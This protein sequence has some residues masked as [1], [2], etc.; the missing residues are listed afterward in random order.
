VLAVAGQ[1]GADGT[2]ETGATLVAAMRYGAGRTLVFAPADSWR[3]RTSASGDEDSMG[4]AFN[5]LWQGIA[6]WTAAGAQPPVEI[7]L[8]DESPA[9]GSMVTAELRVRDASFAPAK[10]EKLGA[11]LQPLTE[12]AGDSSA[13][14]T[15][16][17][18]EIIFAPDSL[19]KSVWR[20]RF[21]LHTRGRFVLETEYAANGKSGRMEKY[22]AVVAASPP[23]PGAA[24]DTLRRVSRESGGELIAAADI[25]AL[26]ERLLAARASTQSV[27]RT[28]ELRTW[29]PL[30][31]IIPLLLSIEWFLR[32]WWRED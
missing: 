24:L 17:Q 7:V 32:R 12:D 4:G 10:I 30:A 23:A 15:A 9:E 19:D 13:A 27:R 14:I 5:A 26:T 29:W 6:L 25:N 1:P 20:A 22:F 2:S 28:W 31:L 8:S 16:Q 21:T 11:L 3:I 18:R